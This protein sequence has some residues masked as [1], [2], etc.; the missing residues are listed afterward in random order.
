[1]KQQKC[2][3]RPHPSLTVIKELARAGAFFSTRRYSALR[4]GRTRKIRQIPLQ[5]IAQIDLDE[6]RHERLHDLSDGATSRLRKVN[7]MRLP[8]MPNATSIK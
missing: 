2:V 6:R 1:M 3:A 7:T 8:R 4:L 5:L